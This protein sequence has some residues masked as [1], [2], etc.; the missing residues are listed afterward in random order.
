MIKG[1]NSPERSLFRAFCH[2][3]RAAV[4]QLVLIGCVL[5][6]QEVKFSRVSLIDQIDKVTCRGMVGSHTSVDAL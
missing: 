3:V 1:Q 4:S 5:M 2:V 6:P